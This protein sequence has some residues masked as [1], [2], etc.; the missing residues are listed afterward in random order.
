M[1]GQRG[2]LSRIKVVGYFP[3]TAGQQ[4]ICLGLGFPELTDT[5]QYKTQSCRFSLSLAV[6]LRYFEL[7]LRLCFVLGNDCEFLEE[8][9]TDSSQ[10][11]VGYTLL[12]LKED[13]RRLCFVP[14]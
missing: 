1:G 2:R 3:E 8:S 4:S 6:A 12:P 10:H 5:L 7:E 9:V 13:F 14:A 11:H